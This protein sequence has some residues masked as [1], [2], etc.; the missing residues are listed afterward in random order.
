MQIQCTVIERNQTKAEPVIA[1]TKISIKKV[2]RDP[3]ALTKRT[4]TKQELIHN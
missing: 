2:T 3:E 4:L 1:R